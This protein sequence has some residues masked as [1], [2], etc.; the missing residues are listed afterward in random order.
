MLAENPH[1]F[2]R[3]R[4]EVLDTLGPHGKVSAENVREMKY[5]RAVLN[6]ERITCSD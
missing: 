5:L 2:L 4:N 1:V 6:G 3:L